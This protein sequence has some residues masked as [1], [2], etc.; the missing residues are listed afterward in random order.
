MQKQ[1]HVCSISDL[2]VLY[3][4]PGRPPDDY[5]DPFNQ[6]SF[7]Y[8]SIQ[9]ARYFYDDECEVRRSFHSDDFGNGSQLTFDREE[10]NSNYGSET[11]APFWNMF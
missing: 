1:K 10:T 2:Y 6:A 11:Y 3:T 5:T 7:Q 8:L 4:S 9:Y